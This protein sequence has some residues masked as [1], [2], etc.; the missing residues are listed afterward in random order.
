MK[1]VLLLGV[2]AACLVLTYARYK[3]TDF[4]DTGEGNMYK[5]NCVTPYIKQLQFTCKDEGFLVDNLNC[6]KLA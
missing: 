5:L 3:S 1:T 6:T 4:T 2:L